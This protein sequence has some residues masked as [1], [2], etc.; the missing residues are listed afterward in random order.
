MISHDNN[1]F[2]LVYF[3]ALDSM[4]GTL[5]DL[6]L[7]QLHKV[8]SITLFTNLKNRLEEDLE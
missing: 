5:H 2:Y 4:L 3:Y 1:G 6:Q 8:N 7:V